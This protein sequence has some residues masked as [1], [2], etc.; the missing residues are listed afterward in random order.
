MEPLED[1]DTFTAVRESDCPTLLVQGGQAPPLAGLPA[2]LRELNEA[3]IAGV[4]QGLESL[5]KQG[6]PGLHVARV[7]E[8]GHM[9]HLQAPEEVGRLVRDFLLG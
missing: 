5:R 3:L 9:L 7:Q 8:A 1:W 4:R 2:P 6:R